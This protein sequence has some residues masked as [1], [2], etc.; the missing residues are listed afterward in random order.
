MKTKRLNHNPLLRSDFRRPGLVLLEVVVS[1]GILLVAMGVIGLIFSNGRH[2]VELAERMTRGMLMTERLISDI[3]TGILELDEQE[4][5]DMFEE[6]SIPGMSWRVEV[7]PSDE[8]EGLMEID[9]DIYMGDPDG[10]EDERSFV[11]STRIFRPEPRGLD[12]ERDFG[13]DEEQIQELTDAIPG[14]TQLLDPTNFDPRTLMAQLDLDSLIELL[15]TLIQAFGANLT[16]GQVDQI[17]QAVESGD[18]SSL[19]NAAGQT[20]PGRT[21]GQDAGHGRQGGQ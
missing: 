14:G 1:L 2:N 12:F 11:M 10:D 13:L 18:L 15:P 5:S 20:G 7:N 16:Q 3:D 9:I 17:I 4:R 8:I 19:Q 6:E 21:G